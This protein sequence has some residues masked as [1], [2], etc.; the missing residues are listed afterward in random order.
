MIWWLPVPLFIRV[1]EV[2]SFGLV[3]VPYVS[4]SSVL[5]V[6]LEQEQQLWQWLLRR[7]QCQGLHFKHSVTCHVLWRACYE[8]CRNY[9][10]T[11]WQLRASLKIPATFA[12]LQWYSPPQSIRLWCKTLCPSLMDLSWKGGRKLEVALQGVHRRN[13]R[14]WG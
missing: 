10:N 5:Q 11:V 9:T 7:C 6:R 14:R 1:H 8:K 3:H 4:L 2:F 13:Y 12:L